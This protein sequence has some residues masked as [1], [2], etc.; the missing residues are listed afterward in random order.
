MRSR[1]RLHGHSRGLVRW[2]WLCQLMAGDKTPHP[3]TITLLHRLHLLIDNIKS[4][5]MATSSKTHPSAS[6]SEFNIWH[7]ENKTIS[8]AP[9]PDE[10]R[11]KRV[12]SMP[13]LGLQKNTVKP[14]RYPYGKLPGPYSIR[15]LHIGLIDRENYVVYAWLQEVE[16]VED[17]AN[18][19]LALSYTWGSPMMK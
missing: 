14:Q 7:W 17:V 1:Y 12:R 18:K 5:T 6:D 3:H 10:H 15:L 11:I 4:V 2:R 9:H 8:R 16:S 13:S 19:Y